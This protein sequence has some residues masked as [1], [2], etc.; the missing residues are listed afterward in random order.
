MQAIDQQLRTVHQPLVRFD[1]PT[2]GMEEKRRRTSSASFLG[3]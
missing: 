3:G 1:I 2:L